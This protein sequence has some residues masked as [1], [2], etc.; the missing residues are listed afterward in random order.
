MTEPVTNAS[1]TTSASSSGCYDRPIWTSATLLAALGTLPRHL[2]RVAPT[3]IG[4]PIDGRLR[5]MIMLAV[6]TENRCWYCQTAHAAF[7]EASGLAPSDVDGLLAGSD[8]GRTAAERAALAY[9]RDLARRGFAS[10]DE[11]LRNELGAH[12][13]AAAVDAIESTA[14][15]MNF[16]NRFGNTFDAARHRATGGC[17]RTEASAVDLALVSALFLPAAA[18]VAPFVGLL[19]L[20]SLLRSRGRR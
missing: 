5:E 19:R 1:S 13:D 2:G 12:F 14:H 7:G 20:R 17:H 8:E 18:C 11:R 15:V 6:A 3:L 10:R 9:A 4:K 16:A